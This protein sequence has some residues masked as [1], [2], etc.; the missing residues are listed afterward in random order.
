M[1]ISDSVIPA[2][3][4]QQPIPWPNSGEFGRRVARMM[5]VTLPLWLATLGVPVC[6]SALAMNFPCPGCGLTRAGLAL[7]RGDFTTAFGLQ[8]LAPLVIPFYLGVLGWCVLN[9]LRYGDARLKRWMGIGIVVAGA[10]LLV[11]WCVRVFGYLGG[12]V[13]V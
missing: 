1:A 4:R 13:P 2:Q 8:P 5:V 3:Q 10:A 6:P 11:V 7:L 12:P 9:Y